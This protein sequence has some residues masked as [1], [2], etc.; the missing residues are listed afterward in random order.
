MS[1]DKYKMK[2]VKDDIGL[3]RN[4]TLAMLTLPSISHIVKLLTSRSFFKYLLSWEFYYEFSQSLKS[5]TFVSQ[6]M[7]SNQ[8][9]ET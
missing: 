1:G 3:M 6:E 4:G 9:G 2:L 7:C 5:D 8:D